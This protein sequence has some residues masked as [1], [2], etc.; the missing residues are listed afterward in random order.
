[1]SEYWL[2]F[3]CQYI[4]HNLLAS[5]PRDAFLMFALLSW[6]RLNEAKQFS[7]AELLRIVKE[8]FFVTMYDKLQHIDVVIFLTKG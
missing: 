7:S 3:Y 4:Q 8:A 6:P 2:F 5:L 1:M